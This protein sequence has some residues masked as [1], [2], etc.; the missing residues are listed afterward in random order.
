MSDTMAAIPEAQNSPRPSL[1][2]A[3]SLRRDSSV[4]QMRSYDAISIHDSDGAALPQANPIAAARGVV[5]PIGMYRPCRSI[6]SEW[7][8]EKW[9]F[10]TGT[11]RRHCQTGL[12]QATQKRNRKPATS[13]HIVADFTG[14]KNDKEAETG[15]TTATCVP[16][17]P[18]TG[19]RPSML[20][21]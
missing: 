11:P 4:S 19:R 8:N 16:R 6:E 2:P 17:N 1:L 12:R 5:L 13:R 7:E 10:F 9:P 3:P 21:K 14:D 15:D 18:V 20:V